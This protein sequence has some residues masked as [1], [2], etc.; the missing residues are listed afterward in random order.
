MNE[1]LVAFIRGPWLVVM[2]LVGYIVVVYLRLR[3]MLFGTPR[4]L[5]YV[6]PVNAMVLRHFGATVGKNCRLHAPIVL[7]GAELSYRNLTIGNGCMFNGMN[8]LDLSGKILL[9]DGVSLGPGVVINT[10]NRFNYNPFLERVLKSE[11]GVRDVHIK[12][13][14]G[15]KANALVIFGVTIGEISVVAGG[16]IVNRDVPPASFVAGMPAKVK[17]TLDG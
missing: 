9:E 14:V 3:W 7:H 8:Y 1:S 5:T 6:A 4:I 11:C 10:H 17:R 12:A 15:I 2:R 16:A 13:G